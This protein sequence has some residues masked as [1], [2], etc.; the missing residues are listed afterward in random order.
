MGYKKK[1]DALIEMHPDVSIKYKS[2]KSKEYHHSVDYSPWENNTLVKKIIQP[3]EDML[4]L[5]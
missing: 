4:T 1:V 3:K 2:L 5:F